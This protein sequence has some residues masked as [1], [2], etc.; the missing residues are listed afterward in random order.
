MA[1]AFR[2]RKTER[3]ATGAAPQALV[4]V[5]RS[6]APTEEFEDDV[7][8]IN[9]L[10]RTLAEARTRAGHPMKLGEPTAYWWTRRNGTWA[11]QLTLPLPAHVTIRHV[12][13]AVSAA[14]SAHA[15]RVQLQ[16]LHPEAGPAGRDRL[17]ST[18]REVRVGA[19]PQHRGREIR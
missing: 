17:P 12:H 19:T 6:G 9:K 15:A 5:S 7:E 16:L 2:E 11:W 10:G 14:R 1:T 4:L 3:R 8:A 18:M 13:D